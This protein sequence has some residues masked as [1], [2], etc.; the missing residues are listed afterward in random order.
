MIRNFRI[1]NKILSIRELS[2]GDAAFQYLKF[3]K[4]TNEFILSSNQST[5]LYNLRNYILKNKYNKNNIL[6]GIF[7]NEL[8]IGNIRIHDIKNGNGI[9]GVI[10]SKKYIGKNIFG[11]TLNLIKKDLKKKLKINKIYL[12]VDVNNY[13][14]IRA[15]K[16]NGFIKEYFFFKKIQRNQI[17]FSKKLYI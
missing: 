9:L 8:H 16:K 7:Y 13:Y 4:T 12:G 6:L 14:A 5:N 17:I 3:L 11:S 15:F 10:I 2:I 1:K